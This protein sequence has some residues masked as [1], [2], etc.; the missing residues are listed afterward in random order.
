[1]RLPNLLVS[2]GPKINQLNHFTLDD[3]AH[4]VKNTLCNIARCV[5]PKVMT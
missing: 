3:P 5:S 4:A 2:G 1:M